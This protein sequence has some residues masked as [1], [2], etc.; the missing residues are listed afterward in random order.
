MA[1][2]LVPREKFPYLKEIIAS[3][4]VVSIIYSLLGNLSE[5]D[6][7]FTTITLFVIIP[8]VLTTVAISV[9]IYT[10][11]NDPKNALM[12]SLFA[13]GVLLTFLGEETWI[14]LE[15]VLNEEPFPS[16]ADVFF[17]CSYPF[18][19]GFLLYIL[20]NNRHNLSTKSI[21]FGVVMSVVILVPTFMVSYDWNIEETELGLMVALM[22]PILSSMLF[23]LS[24]I[25]L[26]FMFTKQCSYFWGLIMIG[27]VL[28]VFADTIFL[29]AEI[30]ESYHDGHPVNVIY[31]A[32]YILWT[33]ALIHFYKSSKQ[34]KNK[35]SKD[36]YSSNKI[37]YSSI[38]KMAIP[39][40]LVIIISVTSFIMYE[41]GM[42]RFFSEEGEWNTCVICYLVIGLMTSFSALILILY[43]NLNNL[44]K[45]RESELEEKAHEDVKMER[46]SAIGEISAR[47]AHDMRNPLSV[48]KNGVEVLSIKQNGD[49]KNEKDIQRLNRAVSRIS[50]QV[51]DV[52]DFVKSKPIN[53]MASSIDDILLSVLSTIKIPDNVKTSIQ[54]SDIIIS[55]DAK[56]LERVFG[57]LFTNSIQAI[58]NT[59]KI[60]VEIIQKNNFVEISI[61]DTGPGIPE[62]DIPRIF[63]P[64]YTTKQE[65][66]GLGLASCKRI[67]E[68]HNG[69]IEFRNN[70][71]TFTIKL[72][73]K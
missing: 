68:D 21:V 35:F 4:A 72:P 59:G 32:S 46:L 12:F 20:K 54:K 7:S 24:A 11:K 1:L 51:D 64:L 62:K 13:V 44:V 57:N 30:D 42:F 45:I 22:Y 6:L 69:S 55:C 26:L 34:T 5:D 58:G 71:T 41:L 52:L 2:E 50:H 29:N 28:W 23:G 8:G 27:T 40:V 65:G 9:A 36:M 53:K 63:E 66:T 17:L 3:I 47:I 73:V 33:F 38:S 60:D 39:L 14:Y 48:I 25:G 43:R 15:H 19:I 10:K 16:I 37:Q 61:K 56:Q 49:P 18:L 67:V 70:P 31:L